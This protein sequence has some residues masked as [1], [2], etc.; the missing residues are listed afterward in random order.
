MKDREDALTPPQRRRGSSKIQL[1]LIL[2]LSRIER[3]KEGGRG[4][5]GEIA[6]EKEGERPG[7]RNNEKEW[8]KN[9]SLTK[10]IKVSHRGGAHSQCASLIK[11]DR[12]HSRCFLDDFS[13]FD[14]HVEFGSETC[15]WGQLRRRKEEE[16]KRRRGEEGRV[17]KEIEVKRL[18]GRGREKEESGQ[19]SREEERKGQKNKSYQP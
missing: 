2:H 10:N 17:R 18:K 3:N 6:K 13:S 5:I 15:A 16:E 8:G 7:R 11:Q 1:L 9:D 19:K 4:G 12:S 14:Q